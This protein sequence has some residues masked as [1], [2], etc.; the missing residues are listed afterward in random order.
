[1][2]K[3]N[4]KYREQEYANAI[5]TAGFQTSHVSTEMGLLVLYMRDILGYGAAK[6]KTELIRFCEEHIPGFDA[7]R[8]YRL[9]HRALKLGQEP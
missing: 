5:Y 4:F 1:M 8:D 3:N 7:I 6:R 2:I 9:L